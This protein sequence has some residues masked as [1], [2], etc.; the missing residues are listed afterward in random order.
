[1]RPPPAHCTLEIKQSSHLAATARAQTRPAVALT[2]GPSETAV[3]GAHH[4]DPAPDLKASSTGGPLQLGIVR[5]SFALLLPAPL[6]PYLKKPQ[7]RSRI[8]MDS[9]NQQRGRSPSAGRANNSLNHSR[10]PSAQAGFNH[11]A[12][13]H[14]ADP[15]LLQSGAYAQS[16]HAPPQSFPDPGFLTAD[17]SQNYPQTSNPSQQ[18]FDQFPVPSAEPQFSSTYDDPNGLSPQSDFS[19]SVNPQYLDA[20]NINTNQGLQDFYAQNPALSAQ[21]EEHGLLQDMQ[22]S[23]NTVQNPQGHLYTGSLSQ[24]Y[25][26]AQTFQQG[27]RSRGQSLSPSSAAV[28]PGQA[29]R[30]WGGI[31]FQGHRRNPSADAYSDMSSH[32]S[33]FVDAVE[34][35]DQANGISPNLN[36]Q[37]DT[38]FVNESLGG[39]G[40]FT[41]SDPNLV[42]SQHVSPGHSNHVSPH[43]SPQQN[44]SFEGGDQFG[45]LTSDPGPQMYDNSVPGMEEFP[46]NAQFSTVGIESGMNNDVE[47]PQINI[48][49]AGPERQPTFNESGGKPEPGMDALSPPS[50]SKSS[51]RNEKELRTNFA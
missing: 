40:N 36:S 15:T 35:F 3:D 30:E 33:P 21:Q 14:G 37:P 5:L 50:R 27:T 51:G 10:S 12:S 38:A 29:S 31:A 22:K 42:H 19:A 18:S 6:V 28:P 41:I 39:L 24:T 34:S 23:Y 48:Q 20:T 43:M 45:I 26:Q 25:E 16:Q 44:M 8:A 7:K 17:F 4:V 9:Q 47:T 1:M 13:A 46:N 49:F 11:Q 2:I 32:H